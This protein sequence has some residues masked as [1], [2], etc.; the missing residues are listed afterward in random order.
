MLHECT[1]DIASIC[2]DWNYLPAASHGKMC[3][4]SNTCFLGEIEVNL[5]PKITI[6]QCLFLEIGDISWYLVISRDFT[7]PI[8][9]HPGPKYYSSLRSDYWNWWVMRPCYP[10][11]RSQRSMSSTRDCKSERVL[12]SSLASTV[13][14]SYLGTQRCL[15]KPS[16]KQTNHPSSGQNTCKKSNRKEQNCCFEMLQ[17]P[18]ISRLNIAQQ[19]CQAGHGV[20][21]APTF[22]VRKSMALDLPR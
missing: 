18:P 5:T 22:L 20:S 1:V 21:C 8:V 2:N 7:I 16:K 17:A 15:W 4:N 9:Q 12:P 11:A 14:F 19:F 3:G 13:K 6:T 10:A